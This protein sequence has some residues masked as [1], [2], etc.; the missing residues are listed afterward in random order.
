MSGRRN[1]KGADEL[2]EEIERANE[3]RMREREQAD[4]ERAEELSKAVNKWLKKSD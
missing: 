1:A 4:R 2:R 3:E